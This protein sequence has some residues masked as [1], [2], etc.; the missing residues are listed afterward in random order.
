VTVDGPF[1]LSQPD[2][3]TELL[4]DLTELIEHHR[5]H[6][7]PY[8]R[9]LTALGRTPGD[10]PARVADL[11]WLP[12]RLFKDHTL[13]SVP[14]AEVFRLVTSSGTT[15]EVSRVYLDRAA[16][17]D[18]Q[19]ALAGILRTVL[20]PARLPMLIVDSV[21]VVRRDRP[22]SARGAGVL[23]MMPYGVRHTFLVDEDGSTDLPA[24]RRFLAAYGAKPFLIFGFTF[25]VWT[26]LADAGLDLSNGIL[27][28]TGG[29]KR[30][31]DRAVDNETFRAALRR[32]GLRRI[33]NFYG[34]AEQ[35]GTVFLESSGRP[36]LYCPDFAD[37]IVRDP[38]TWAEAP[39][40]TPG[41]L[42]VISTL[43]RSHPGHLLLTEDLGVVHGVDD[44]DWPGKRF[45]VLG[46]LARA[47]VRGCGDAG[48]SP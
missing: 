2:R 17:A 19:R 36:G 37:V 9:I 43:P 33:H 27:L 48:P 1:R 22:L 15:G 23:G 13:R 11:P 8:D 20:G 7:A 47:P 41:V 25:L 26:H 32:T 39:V 5:R 44:G 42:Q 3:E 28:H 40:G 21:D 18:Q 35:V 12:V 16:A 10:R 31:A 14:E 34:M 24:A 45:S 29:W 6:C 30:L 38:A 46:R 4:R